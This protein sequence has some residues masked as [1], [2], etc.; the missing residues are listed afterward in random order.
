M[1]PEILFPECPLWGN[2]L[3]NATHEVSF[4]HVALCKQHNALA[5]ISNPF[6]KP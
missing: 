1:E 5:S 2:R 4:P 3:K 6:Q